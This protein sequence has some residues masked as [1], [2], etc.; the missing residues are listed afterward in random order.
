MIG[1]SQFE[2]IFVVVVV[3]VNTDVEVTAYYSQVTAPYDNLCSVNL[4]KKSLQHTR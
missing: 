2:T 1:Q 3:V 4:K